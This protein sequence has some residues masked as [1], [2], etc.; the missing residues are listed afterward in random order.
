MDLMNDSFFH[1]LRY[2]LHHDFQ[3]SVLWFL[4]GAGLLCILP[5]TVYR[6]IHHEWAIAAVGGLVALAIIFS[7]VFALHTGETAVASRF[8][9]VVNAVLGLV[10]IHLLGMA[11]AFWLYPL[12]VSNF[13]LIKRKYAWLNVLAMHGYMLFHKDFFPYLD[14]QLT[15]SATTI[16]VCCMAHI[17]SQRTESQRQLLETIA[18]R[19]ALTGVANRLYF[20]EE[21]ARAHQ[22]FGRGQEEC[23]L[24]VIDIDHFKRFNDTW[25]HEAGDEVLIRLVRFVESMV[26][27]TDRFFRY[28]G[29]EFVLLVK[30]CSASTLSAIAEK[31]CVQ[32]AENI[33]FND[34]RITVS[35][36]TAKLRPGETPEQWFI[37]A[38]AALY[39]AKNN[40]RNQVI[41][42]D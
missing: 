35:I 15:F 12:F 40:G 34:Q 7:A 42:D 5:F 21:L 36:G 8:F 27:K 10:H 9:S 18:S 13:F 26:R 14:F 25:G 39:R 23:G 20:Q 30:P 33:R 2:R 6:L 29:E 28:G 16:F 32:V 37:R 4:G 3:L 24:M 1:R 31:L 22:S 19:D 11:G 41:N 38:D 17:F